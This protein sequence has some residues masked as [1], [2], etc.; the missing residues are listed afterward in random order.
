MN[1]L[2]ARLLV[3]FFGLFAMANSRGATS[4]AA[5]PRPA[6]PLAN[7]KFSPALKA[8]AERDHISLFKADSGAE[9]PLAGDSTVAWVGAS[10]DHGTRQWL[11]QLRRGVATP[12]EQKSK[13]TPERKKYLSW[14]SIVTFKSDV[15]AL[16][17]WIAGPV[18]EGDST[19]ENEIAPVKR[20]RVFVPADYLRL[21]LDN[22]VRVNQ[23]VGR[24]IQALQKDDPKF[25]GHGIYALDQ[26]IKSEN[27]ERSKVVAEKIGFTPEM[28]RAWVG[29][30]VALEGFYHLA[31]DVPM[32]ESIADV[33]ANKP[34]VWKLAKVATG[35][36]FKS[37]LGGA[38]A[39]PVDPG[40]MGLA[41]VTTETFQ[42]PFSFEFGSDPILSG[43]MVVTSPL[44]PY[45]TSAGI[46]A[47]LAIHPKDPVR[48]VQVIIVG[49]TRGP[50]ADSLPA[51]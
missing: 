21:G 8:A 7:V 44:P 35:T 33:A 3:L 48:Q 26:P 34:S 1:R 29:G 5:P 19:K 41:P 22:S 49:G 2:P 42:T 28:E 45:D 39:R 11:I 9:T 40:K 24:R 31:N 15:Q 16:D 50:V 38:A 51:R 18:S 46:L 6:P 10:D 13:R 25:N 43:V 32:L 23:Q 12:E 20:V 14:G 30:F 47:I 36:K 37:S 27:I 4:S 17:L